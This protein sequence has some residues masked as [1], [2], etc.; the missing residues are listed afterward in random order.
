MPED[1]IIVRF[2]TK[3]FW[4]LKNSFLIKYSLKKQKLFQLASDSMTVLVTHIYLY[5]ME[6][7]QRIIK[8]YAVRI[9]FQTLNIAFQQ[10]LNQVYRT[11]LIMILRQYLSDKDN[12]FWN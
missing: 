2:L 5:K 8:S 9:G 3:K 11:V 6:S 1:A 12:I 10:T 7:D 4:H